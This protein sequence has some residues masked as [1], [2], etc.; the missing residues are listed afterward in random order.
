[1]TSNHTNCTCSEHQ[2]PTGIYN[3]NDYSE[4]MPYSFKYDQDFYPTDESLPD[5][6][7]DPVIPGARVALDKVGIAPVDLPI[8]DQV[9]FLREQ[10]YC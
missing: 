1:M 7:I 9:V 3:Y 8:K 6:Q 4:K 5:P 10:L 2:A